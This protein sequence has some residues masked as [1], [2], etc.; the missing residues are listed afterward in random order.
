V[1]LGVRRTLVSTNTRTLNPV[2][3][4]GEAGHV[5]LPLWGYPLMPVINA[6]SDY[7]GGFCVGEEAGWA[8]NPKARKEDVASIVAGRCDRSPDISAA[9]RISQLAT[10]DI[11]IELEG[12]E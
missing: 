5:L 12:S 8:L 1:T 3:E 7:C 9:A 11:V 10:F 6:A 4:D 2:T